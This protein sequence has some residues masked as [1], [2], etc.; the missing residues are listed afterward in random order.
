MLFRLLYFVQFQW[1]GDSTGQEKK[2]HDLAVEKYEKEYQKYQENRIK[3]LDWIA[4]N[5]RIKDKVK[6]NLENSTTHWNYITRLIRI[7]CIWTNLS[8]QTFTNR[9]FNKNRE[10]WFTSELRPWR[11]DWRRVLS[12]KKMSLSKIYYSP[13]GFWK[14]LD[15]V[16]KLA[17]EAGVS[18][19]VAK[20]W[21]MKQAIWQIYLPAPK[22]SRDRRFSLHPPIR[23]IKLIFFASPMAGSREGKEGLQVRHW[24]SS[25]SR[26][27]SGPLNHPTRRLQ[28]F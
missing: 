20:L 11:S 13:K 1:G 9:V 4:T 3:L 19:D 5:D 10:R 25:M 8:F 26:A 2:R 7:R 6:Q 16:K 24:Q 23:F 28:R 18:Q 14:G 12:Y 15:A 17:Q 22:I 27:D 21:L